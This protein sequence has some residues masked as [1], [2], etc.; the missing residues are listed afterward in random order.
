MATM[1]AATIAV[2]IV[3]AA[4]FGFGVWLQLQSH[5]N[6]NTEQLRDSSAQPADTKSHNP[7]WG[8]QA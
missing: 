2:L 6:S 1:N 5:R 8:P 3:T 4:F 7:G